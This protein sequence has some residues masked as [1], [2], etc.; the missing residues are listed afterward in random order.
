MSRACERI[1]DYGRAGADLSASAGA[2]ITFRF[3][4]HRSVTPTTVSVHS[5]GALR[6]PLDP[7]ALSEWPSHLYAKRITTDRVPSKVVSW[8]PRNDEVST[9]SREVGAR[10]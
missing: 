2:R 5:S 3:V 4:R 10:R 8:D 9:S 6:V 7:M 1:A